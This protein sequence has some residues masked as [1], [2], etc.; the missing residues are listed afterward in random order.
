MT[1]LCGQTL[2]LFGLLGSLAGLLAG[3]LGIGGGIILVPLFLWVFNALNYAPE[4]VVHLAFGTSLCVI[5]P[6]ALGSALGH[7]QRGNLE[8]QQVRPLALGGL[9]GA[10]LGAALAVRLPAAGLKG[11]FGLMQMLAALQMLLGSARPRPAG[12]GSAASGPLLA[13]GCGGGLFAAFFGAGG[14][15][16]LVPLMLLV[17][18]MP[19]H[20]AVGN[21][22]AL[23]VVSALFGTLSYLYHGWQVA[24]LPPGCVGYVHWQAAA[25]VIPFTLLFANLG[26]RLATR[27]SQQRLVRLFALLL[28]LI[29][30]QMLVEVIAG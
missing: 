18:R 30:G 15:F 24:G 6:S 1:L 23:I 16:V 12:M 2:L 20:L 28:L 22:S 8:L 4:L 13:I 10:L 26:V 5:L 29:G 19:I 7:R 17:L 11:A 27:F 21:S 3:L 9:I 14:G 25:L